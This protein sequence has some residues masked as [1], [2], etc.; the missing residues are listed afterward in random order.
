MGTVEGY[1]AVVLWLPII[2]ISG[3]RTRLESTPPAQRIMELRKPMT[4]PRPRM[5]LMASKLT[6]MRARSVSVRM[7]GTN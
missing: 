7:T 1:T 5:K 3:T 2:Q 4:Y 6:A